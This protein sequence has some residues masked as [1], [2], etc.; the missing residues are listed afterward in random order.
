MF[1]LLYC[2]KAIYQSFPLN[3]QVSITRIF[4]DVYLETVR[5][6][7]TNSHKMWPT[8]KQCAISKESSIIITFQLLKIDIAQIIAL[9]IYGL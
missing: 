8:T 5:M 6:F 3:Y 9:I 2:I 1:Y 7:Y 4:C